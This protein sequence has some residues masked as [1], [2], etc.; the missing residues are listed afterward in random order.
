V[1]SFVSI[2][3][4]K[5]NEYMEVAKIVMVQVLSLVENERTFSNLTC[6]KNKFVGHT[7]QVECLQSFY[8][9]T[10]SPTMASL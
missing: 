9:I 2:L 1:R 6:R 5:I 7:S 10:N 8:T 3:I 4:W